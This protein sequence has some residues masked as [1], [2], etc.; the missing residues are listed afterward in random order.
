MWGIFFCGDITVWHPMKSAFSLSLPPLCLLTHKKCSTP[1]CLSPLPNRYFHNVHLSYHILFPTN[2]PVCGSIPPP[3]F[4]PTL[5][6]TPLLPSPTTITTPPP[7]HHHHCHHHHHHHSPHPYLIRQP[8]T[9]T[10]TSINWWYK[11]CGKMSVSTKQSDQIGAAR[12]SSGHGGPYSDGHYLWHRTTIAF[13]IGAR[14]P[15][16]GP[17]PR[18]ALATPVMQQSRII[19]IRWEG[20][21]IRPAYDMWNENLHQTLDIMCISYR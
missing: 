19:C 10:P 1:H 9:L 21:P 3:P 4:T 16:A 6:T 14:V 13:V 5:P 2:S 12:N 18:L 7:H 20:D 17:I 11:S 15:G 8:R